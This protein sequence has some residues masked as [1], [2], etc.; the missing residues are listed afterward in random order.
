MESM[1]SSTPSL[2]MPDKVEDRGGASP[3][4]LAP[5]ALCLRLGSLAVL[6]LGFVWLVLGLESSGT[7]GWDETGHC[8]TG[9]RLGVA[10]RTFDLQAFWAEF[11]RPDFYT[12]LGRLGMGLGF[13]FSDSFMAPRVATLV[14]WFVTIGLA[15]LLARRVAGSAAADSAMFWTVLGGTTCY[16]GTDYSR[17]AY[18]EPWSALATVASVLMYLHARD[19]GTRLAAFACGLLLGA[20]LLVKYTYS[21]YVIGAVGLS[22]LWDLARRPAGVRPGLLAAWCAVGLVLVLLWWFVLPLPGGLDMGRQHWGAFVEYLR[23]ASDL[24]SVGPWTLLIYWPFKACMT[25]LVFA[26]QVAGLVWGLRRWHEPGA[27]LCAILALVSALGYIAYPFRIDRFLVPNIFGAWV[28]AGA[29]LARLQQRAPARVRPGVGVLLVGASWL[30]LGAGVEWVLPLV[31]DVPAEARPTAAAQVRTWTNPFLARRAPA[32]GPAGLEAVLDVPAEHFEPQMPFAWIGGTGTELPRHLVAW[33]MF[34]RHGD[35]RTLHLAW[36]PGDD[37]WED[38]GFDP[39]SFQKWVRRF[40]QVGVLDPPDPKGRP[41][42]F[43]VQFAEWMDLNPEFEET[44]RSQVELEVRPG[45]LQ[46][47]TVKIYRRR[48]S[49]ER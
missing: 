5:S 10:L 19:R 7:P 27:R 38:P 37:L 23:K 30:T 32:V 3:L 25:L 9:L 14:A 16:L 21:L 39:A 12:P 43:E 26:L 42:P 49:G 20:G 4:G 28:L 6:L 33:R 41:R 46:D 40:V 24:P 47:F 29:L 11:L 18:Q 44:A 2:Q 17:A 8:F 15:G 22:G 36:R 48:S 45:E 34:Q 35:E 31:P 13:L 1:P